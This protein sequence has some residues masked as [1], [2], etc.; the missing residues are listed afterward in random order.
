[1]GVS[2]YYSIWL[3]E[4]F[5]WNR[6]YRL[7]GNLQIAPPERLFSEYFFTVTRQGFCG[8]FAVTLIVA[9]V[10]LLELAHRVFS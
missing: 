7:Y 10:A 2:G 8:F 5:H 6:L 3:N 9:G 1:M 4:L